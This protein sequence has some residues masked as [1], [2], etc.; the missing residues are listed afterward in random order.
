MVVCSV[1]KQL[2]KEGI[3]CDVCGSPL[4][5]DSISSKMANS[6]FGVGVGIIK[7]GMKSGDVIWKVN[8][9][10]SDYEK[11]IEVKKSEC[12]FV[13]DGT[14]VFKYD[15][16]LTT[17]RSKFSCYFVLNDFS[18][19]SDYEICIET[20]IMKINND[21]KL[22]VNANYNITVNS[23]DIDT[24][25]NS[26]IAIKD[27]NWTVEDIKKIVKENIH[28]IIKMIV[29]E[30]IKKDNGFDLRNNRAQIQSCE[31]DI[32]SK[33]D[34]KLSNYSLKLSKYELSDVIIDKHELYEIL[35]NNL[36]SK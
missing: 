34:D 36:Y 32:R 29:L 23:I 15:E 21:E 2:S 20:P 30:C 8:K 6:G 35:A 33:L 16:S 14:G 3:F 18:L 17:T 27:D 28:E 11:K 22:K 24:F 1:C 19:D 9:L 7:S 10:P 25:F 26:L 4:K 13:N 5:A 31:Q 12:V